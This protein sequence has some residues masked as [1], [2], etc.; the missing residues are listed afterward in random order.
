[1]PYLSYNKMAESDVDAIVAYLR[2]LPAINNQVPP[3]QATMPSLPPLES[4]E[5][6][7]PDPSD[8]AVRGA[9]LVT[10]V[11]ACS[12]CHTALNPETGQPVLEQYMAGGQPFE[13]PWGV[14]YAA[15]VTPHEAT[16]IGRWEDEDI[17]RVFREG[18]RIDGRRVVVMPWRAYRNLTDDD[19]TAV[20]YF[21]RNN[22]QPVE[23]KVP[24]V[25]LAE[26]VLE[27]VP[28]AEQGNSS[29]FMGAGIMVV[30]IALVV[31]VMRR[32]RA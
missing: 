20:I 27:V 28:I 3:R 21:L 1:M 32:R 23:N 31:V 29:L 17:E 14:V 18:V 5:V 25:S 16:G 26:G 2:T 24:A 11:S 4:Q 30:L 12:D 7:A 8:T 22:L 13:G 9:Y 15:N 6:T 10:A 19:L